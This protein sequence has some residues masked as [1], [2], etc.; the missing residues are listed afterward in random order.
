M[1]DCKLCELTTT[2][3]RFGDFAG[4]PGLRG[5]RVY[6]DARLI[7]LLVW[8]SG[9]AGQLLVVP[10][11]HAASFEALGE[12]MQSHLFK[13]SQR[14][15][16]SLGDAGLDFINSEVQVVAQQS[17]QSAKEA[18]VYLTVSPQPSAHDPSDTAP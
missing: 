15:T 3:G 14:A 2:R 10:K 16:D 7:V 5:H 17:Q 6:E 18:H 8:R 4:N 13:I 9:Q 12:A 11:T 1:E